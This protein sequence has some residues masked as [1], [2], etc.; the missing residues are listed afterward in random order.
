MYID[1]GTGSMLIQAA[2]AGL[3]TVIVFFRQIAD[4]C[5]KQFRRKGKRS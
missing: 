4:W 5:R 1:A 3:F 2:A